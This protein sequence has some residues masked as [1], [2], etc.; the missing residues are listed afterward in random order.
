MEQQIDKGAQHFG[1]A[2]DRSVNRRVAVQ[3]RPTRVTLEN[4][5]LVMRIWRSIVISRATFPSPN[6]ICKTADSG[7]YANSIHLRA[8]LPLYPRENKPSLGGV[9]PT[10][11]A[12]SG[13]RFRGSGQ[14]PLGAGR[15]SVVDLGEVG[16]ARKLGPRRRSRGGATRGFAGDSEMDQNLA[17]RFWL[18][19]RC[20]DLHAPVALRACQRVCYEHAF[21]QDRPR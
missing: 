19:D 1:S 12:Y 18:C 16:R 13:P 11:I 21:Q 6:R 7:C 4:V 20:Q 14:S 17:Y 3:L 10:G 9:A 15:V 2:I 8:K 5:A